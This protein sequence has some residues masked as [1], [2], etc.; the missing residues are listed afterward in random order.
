MA[1]AGFVE[2][3]LGSL[4]ANT[5]K[6]FRAV[7]DYILRNLRI[8]QPIHGTPSENFQGYF[9]EATT[10][11]VANTEFSIAHGLGKT[12]YLVL[13]VLP[14]NTVGAKIVPLT[15]TRAADA[16]RIYLSSSATSAAVVLYV[17][18]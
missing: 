18:A 4:D 9:Y 2:A 12:P 15:V 16:S 13:P 1:T 17:E 3:L 8:G 7:F 10:D 11:A 14:L 6:A 5:R